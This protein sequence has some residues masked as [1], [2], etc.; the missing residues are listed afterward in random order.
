MTEQMRENVRGGMLPR[1]PSRALV[2]GAGREP[3][4]PRRPHVE[5][6]TTS[7]IS[8]AAS[9]GPTAGLPARD[10]DWPNRRPHRPRPACSAAQPLPRTAAA[11]PVQRALQGGAGGQ[12]AGDDCGGEGS[13]GGGC[14]RG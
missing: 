7:S 3:A 11:S 12:G 2:L 9:N 14:N 4:T 1:R 8:P 5:I 13:M 10:Q 6:T